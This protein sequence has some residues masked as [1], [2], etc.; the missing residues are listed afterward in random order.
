MTYFIKEC[1]NI[2]FDWKKAGLNCIYLKPK[3]DKSL[4]FF[5][6]TDKLF[7]VI[8]NSSDKNVSIMTNDNLKNDFDG[9]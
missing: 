6:Q 7:K 8:K 9:D 3:R 4:K 1:K 5:R 2:N